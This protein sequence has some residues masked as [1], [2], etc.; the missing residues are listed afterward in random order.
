MAQRGRPSGATA[1]VADYVTEEVL[2]LIERE[3]LGRGDRL[4]AVQEL[5]RRLS[6]AAPTV[7]ESLR[8]LQ[9]LGI[10]ELR[11][12]SGVY[13]RNAQRRVLLANPYPGQLE[14]RTIHDLLEARLLIEPHLTALAGALATDEELAEL[15]V[16]LD[17]A[18][19]SLAGPDELLH[20]LNMS[21]HRG[22]ARLSGS[23]VLSQAIESIIDVYAA[24]QMVILRL[25]DD[26]RRDHEEHLGIFEALRRRDAEEA[27]ELMRLHLEGVRSVLSGRLEPADRG[28]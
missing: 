13:V 24:E 14:A 25:Y 4:P 9:A 27:A 22:V 20:G 16:A 19:E 10:V 7:R 8:Q 23:S 21:F 2:A 17:Q 12:G 5:A 18:G 1:T 15:G 28:V 6:V 26:R 3:E 11:H